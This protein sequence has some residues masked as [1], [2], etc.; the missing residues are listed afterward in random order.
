[1]RGL[2]LMSPLSQEFADPD[3]DTAVDEAQDEQQWQVGG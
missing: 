2:T 3:W 1:M